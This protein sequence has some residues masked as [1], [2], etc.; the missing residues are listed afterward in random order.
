MAPNADQNRL[1]QRLNNNN[2]NSNNEINT[3]DIDTDNNAATAPT[4]TQ[5]KDIKSTEVVIDGTIYDL[6]SF[7]HPG[8][9]S[10][11]LFGGNDVTVQYKMIHPY[12][13]SKHLEKMAV[14]GKIDP[15]DIK[16]DYAFGTDFER[17]IKREVFKIVRRGK[18]FG[19]TGYFAR[20]F[21]YI[22]LYIVLD[23]YWTT[24]PTTLK[25]AIAFGVAQ[26][27]IGLNVQ[28]DANHG[29]VSKKA[30][31]ND[32]LGF[33]AD[34]IGGCKWN[35]QCQHWTHHAFTNHHLKD[36]YAVNAEPFVLFNDYPLGHPKRKFYHSFQAI[37]FLPI[38]SGYFFPWSSTHKHSLF[39]TKDPKMWESEWT[40]ISSRVEE[41]GPPS[42]DSPTFTL[43][44]SDPL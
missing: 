27:L 38:L 18:E 15:N 7:M 28:H 31:I 33:G 1:R 29:A 32:F 3:N 12:H 10:V 26:A 42:S 37:F 39:S 16:E 44:S 13:T 21:F 35:W 30:W 40:M 23:Y 22:G 24:Q 2:S 43:I 34:M 8:G 19:T 14:M 9:D 5:L 11:L 4:A 25:L 41:S 20:A 36:P 17:E 6:K